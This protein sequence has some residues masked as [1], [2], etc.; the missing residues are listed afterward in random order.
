MSGSFVPA[1][2]QLNLQ[3]VRWG[4]KPA[5]Y[6]PANISGVADLARGTITGRVLGPGCSTFVFRRQ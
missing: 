2:G 3:F 5:N 6:I 1:N 4:N